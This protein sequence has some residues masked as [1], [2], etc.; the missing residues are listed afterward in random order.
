MDIL[1]PLDFDAI[2]TSRPKK[3][4]RV[5][6]DHGERGNVVDKTSSDKLCEMLKKKATTCN[7]KYN[8]CAWKLSDL[9]DLRNKFKAARYQRS[10]KWKSSNRLSL[11]VSLKEGVSPG[12]LTVWTESQMGNFGVNVIID[13]QQRITTLFHMFDNPCTYIL[14]REYIQDILKQL[15]VFDI[16]R[17][18]VN[19]LK[20]M[21]MRVL[22]DTLD[23]TSNPKSFMSFVSG[24]EFTSEERKDYV[25]KIAPSVQVAIKKE[26]NIMDVNIHMDAYFGIATRSKMHDVYVRLNEMGIQLTKFE[27]FAPLCATTEMPILGFIKDKLVKFFATHPLVPIDI[28]TECI[29]TFT[30]HEYLMGTVL[31]LRDK[32]PK[33]FDCCYPNKPTT[34]L[35]GA[36][37]QERQHKWDNKSIDVISKLFLVIYGKSCYTE[38]I[39]TLPWK[40]LEEQQNMIDGICNAIQECEAIHEPFEKPA[41]TKVPYRTHVN[42][43]I[44]NLVRF[45]HLSSFYH[46]DREKNKQK[47]RTYMFGHAFIESMHGTKAY[48]NSHTVR[49][50]KERVADEH[51]MYPAKPD[52]IRKALEIGIDA[53][54]RNSQ[55]FHKKTQI[56]MNILSYKY[57]IKEK[58]KAMDYEHMV[59][60]ER[61]K[62]L[63]IRGIP[64]D[65]NNIGNCGLLY[66]VA[67]R[68]KGATDMVSYMLSALPGITV[69]D[70]VFKNRWHCTQDDVVRGHQHPR[71]FNE[72]VRKRRDNIK[73]SMAKI[74]KITIE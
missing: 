64:V 15:Q 22:L 28:D 9:Y 27:A 40:T 20:D 10:I 7:D 46:C 16:V 23:D 74:L 45:A 44:A 50:H 37:V 53:S 43:F 38:L 1:S 60:R 67:N 8:Y 30:L 39:D 14:S 24:K 6:K 58:M 54:K 11:W 73:K 2:S 65:M 72:F 70:S 18:W 36:S 41:T 3:K 33:F 17:G 59:C 32:Y 69:P 55:N 51:Y 68:K 19:T 66:F 13:G 47:L 63:Q 35:N 31:Y 4:R 25:T 57:T 71:N 12:C 49:H 42:L 29:T 26:S 34:A 52:E 5:L 56:I 21:N 62:E 48:N 61:C